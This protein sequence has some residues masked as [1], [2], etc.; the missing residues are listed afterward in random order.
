M[1]ELQDLATRR[2]TFST[3]AGYAID[4]M[5]LD[6]GDGSNLRPDEIQFVT[7]N[8]FSTLGVRPVVGPGL[9]S[10]STNDAPGAE[11]VAVM[12]HIQWE[13][14]GGDSAMVGRIVRVNNVPVRIVGI[15]PVDFEG[16]V[17]ESGTP[18]LWMPLVARAAIKQTTAHALV[19][20]DSTFLDAFGRLASGASIESANALVS[21]VARSWAPEKRRDETVSYSSDVVR[22]RGVTDVS[23]EKQVLYLAGIIAAGALLI[24]LVACTNVSALLVGTAVARRREIAIRLS[25]GASRLRIVRQ[26]VTETAMIALVGGALGLA[27]FW[28]IS[29]V[30]AAA[31][32]TGRFSPDAWTVPFTAAVALGTGIIFGLSPALHAT[33]V[34][35]SQAL[36]DSGGGGT[37]RSRLQRSFIVAQ[38]V[39]TQPLLVAIGMLI[40]VVLSSANGQITNRLA[41]QVVKVQF[42]TSGGIGSREAKRARIAQVMERVAA[43]P[44]VAAVVPK[45]AVADIA[46]FRVHEADRGNGPRAQE[47]LRTQVEG[48]PPGYFA[49]QGIKMLRGREFVA[50]DTTS[51]DLSV[52]VTSDFARG[53][54]GTADPIGKRLQMIQPEMTIVD[55]DNTSKREQQP[56]KTATVIG[57]FD[58]TGRALRSDAQVYSAQG[59]RWDQ[60]TY[61]V[62]SRTSGLAIVPDVRRIAREMV[63]DIPL[64]GNGVATLEQLERDARNEVLQI[65][66]LATGAGLLTLLLTSIGLYGL[67]GLAVRQRHREI[68]IRVALGARPRRVIGMFLLTGVR[69]SVLGVVLGL[70]LS[71]FALKFIASQFS[72]NFSFN[73]P[74]V[75]SAIAATVVAVASLASWLPARRAAGVD[76]LV[77][78]RTE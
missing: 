71:V 69:L 61:L 5:V 39:L 13:Q 31:I 9:P 50:T 77:A 49:F 10:I 54:W 32:G 17:I 8:F 68:G 40:A 2:E 23:N 26:L 34:D 46:D 7:P 38:I 70:P 21:V 66:S 76:P 6:P 37:S 16:P 59:S 24:L 30:I 3:V 19:S 57:V 35:V 14:L 65:S 42:G 78:I 72:E 1:P 15:A 63:P 27:L 62:R 51:A 73:M 55:G 18:S 74:I 12:S 48:T 36:K 41:D 28:G 58:T 25:L 75:G 47:M 22:L 43:L 11:L 20:R 29:R 33:R 60:D 45:S 56:P 44:G 53:F 4:H 67:V 52:I 64:Y